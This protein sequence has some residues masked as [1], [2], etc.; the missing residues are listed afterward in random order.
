MPRWTAI[1]AARSSAAMLKVRIWLV[2]GMLGFAALAGVLAFVGSLSQSDPPTPPA[3]TPVAVATGDATTAAQEYVAGLPI[4]I[5]IA[6]GLPADALAGRKPMAGVD[7]LT[8]E[9]FSRVDTQG[10]ILEQHRFLLSG[11]TGQ[12]ERR[13]VVPMQIVGNQGVL[14][15]VPALERVLRPAALPTHF[16]WSDVDGQQNPSAP[17]QAAVSKWATAYLADDRPT[18][19]T[20]TGDLQSR[21]YVGLGEF[22]ATASAIEAFVPRADKGL[23]LVRVAISATGPGGWTSQLEYDLLVSDADSAL[24]K[25]VAW[26]PPG[27]GPSLAPYQNALNGG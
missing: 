1:P 23:S 9:G 12:R 3:P 26:G 15:A 7:H 21:S 10:R 4:T 24:P 17:L 11:T 22:T 19:A 6:D 25:I 8:W 27:A 18:L 13:L 14:A 2:L 5:P 16:N 20:T